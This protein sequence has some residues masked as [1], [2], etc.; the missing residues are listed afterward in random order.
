MV[1]YAFSRP[2]ASLA[3][4][5]VRIRTLH[6]YIDCQMHLDYIFYIHSN[7]DWMTGLLLVLVNIVRVLCMHCVNFMFFRY[8]PIIIFSLFEC[9]DFFLFIFVAIACRTSEQQKKRTILMMMKN[10]DF[11]VEFFMLQFLKFNA[12]Q[13]E[14]TNAFMNSPSYYW[15]QK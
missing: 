12:K 14:D 8:T 2:S 1:C 5:L 11:A 9:C 3:G 4:W 10:D 7:V 6:Q 15:E 13:N